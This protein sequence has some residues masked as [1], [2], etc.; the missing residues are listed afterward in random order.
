[1]CINLT[2]VYLS[3]DSITKNTIFV[4]PVSQILVFLAITRWGGVDND[5]FAAWRRFGG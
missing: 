1:L 3:S 5:V 2:T 4:S